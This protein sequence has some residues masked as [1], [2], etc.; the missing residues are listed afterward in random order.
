[1]T[2]T[3]RQ[4]YWLG[5]E[6]NCQL[7]KTDNSEQEKCVQPQVFNCIYSSKRAWVNSTLY[8]HRFTWGINTC[9]TWFLSKYLP[10]SF[11]FSRPTLFNQN[12]AWMIELSQSWLWITVWWNFSQEILSSKLCGHQAK[13]SNYSMRFFYLNPMK[14]KLIMNKPCGKQKYW[15]TD[16]TKRTALSDEQDIL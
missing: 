5:C 13:A 1:M 7:A 2:N 10:Y 12:N 16:I 6:S 11:L 3:N 8:S 14:N 9:Y 15:S 4:N